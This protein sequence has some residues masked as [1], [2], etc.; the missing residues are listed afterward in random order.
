MTPG[1]DLP[2]T[3]Q[4]VV[5]MLADAAA[6]TPAAIALSCTG[7]EVSYRDYLN[8]VAILA[9]RMTEIGV[10]GERVALFMGNSL[11]MAIAMFAVHAAGA[12]AVP[13]NPVYTARETA[14]ILADS[15][16]VATIHD[17]SASDMLANL[18][19]AG[20]MIG[21]EGTSLLQLAI[22]TAVQLRPPPSSV[23]FATLH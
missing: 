3:P 22:E 21:V 8:S 7:T 19:S 5:H 11:D 12:Q 4:T 2:S 16:P 6:D 18:D 10:R 9:H 13:I 15:E 1:G 20:E 23:D 17:M 14:Y